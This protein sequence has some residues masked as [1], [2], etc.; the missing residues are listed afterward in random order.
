MLNWLRH[1]LQDAREMRSADDTLVQ[2]LISDGASA[3]GAPSANVQGL[4][5]LEAAAGC[6]GA[7]L[8]PQVLAAPQTL[9]RTL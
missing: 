5:A 8:N 6:S 1:K 7:R 2:L 4:G 9:S 3:S